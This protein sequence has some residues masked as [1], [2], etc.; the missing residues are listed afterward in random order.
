MMILKRAA[1]ESVEELFDKRSDEIHLYIAKSVCDALEKGVNELTLFV[2]QPDGLEMHCKR[3]SYLDTLHTNLPYIEKQEEYEL[4][5]RV[6]FWINKLK[7]EK[8]E[9]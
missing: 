1:D 5:E 4:C 2:I 7:L 9:N 8:Y 3:D 6:H